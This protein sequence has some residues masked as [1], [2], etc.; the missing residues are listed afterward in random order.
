MR[1]GDPFLGVCRCSYIVFP[2]SGLDISAFAMSA[3]FDG[4]L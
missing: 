4:V 3:A 2:L 1:F